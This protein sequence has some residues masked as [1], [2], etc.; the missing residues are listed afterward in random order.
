[1]TELAKEIMACMDK[2]I[3]CPVDIL[4]QGVGNSEAEVEFIMEQIKIARGC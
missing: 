1:M 4:A 3:A 2:G